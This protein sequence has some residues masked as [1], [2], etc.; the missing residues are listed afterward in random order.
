MK[1]LPHALVV[2]LILAVAYSLAFLCA[3]LVTSEAL[4]SPTWSLISNG[5][6]LAAHVLIAAGALELA[7]SLSGR[8][9]IG[10]K[11]VAVAQV[12]LVLMVGF[13]IGLELWATGDSDT[14]WQVISVA[15]YAH[16]VITLA[17]AVGFALV[18]RPL[19]LTIVLPIIA[20]AGVPVPVIGRLLYGDHIHS[21]TATIVVET[22][23]YIVL[24]ALQLAAAWSRRDELVAVPS[25]DGAAAF[26]RASKALWLRVISALSLAGFTFLVGMSRSTDAIG[27]LRAVMVLAPIVDAVALVLFA[28]AVIALARTTVAPWLLTV[29][30]AFTLAATGMMAA[31]VA[32][33]YEL[34]YGHHRDSL[35]DVASREPML[36]GLSTLI[37]PFI[38]GHGIVLVLVAVA[39]LARERN[40]ENVRE[41]VVI[42]TGVFVALMVGAL[43][44]THFL[45]GPVTGEAGLAVFSLFAIAG[46]T[47]YALTIAAKLCAQGAELLARDPAG[48]PAA[49]V[50]SS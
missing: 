1:R 9:A 14:I 35:Y 3:A 15:R 20:V 34:F 19:G 25:T 6:D 24:A 49:K 45:N 31:R 46:A 41:N 32:K 50:V 39:K 17:A 27:L 8:A 29:A 36:G 11:L 28:R 5:V 7:R 2:G 16:S 23:P 26:T 43:L 13:W 44:M 42:R 22:V 18:A 33:L 38:A 12:A 30:A 37:V 47:L 4:F 10:A 21:Q 40:V 48:L